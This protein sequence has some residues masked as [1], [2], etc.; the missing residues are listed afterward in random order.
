MGLVTKVDL[1]AALGISAMTLDAYIE[2]G[3]IVREPVK[4]RSAHLFAPLSPERLAEI[5]ELAHRH[6]AAACSRNSAKRRSLAQKALKRQAAPK[7]SPAPLPKPERAVKKVASPKPMPSVAAVISLPSERRTPK[8]R[9]FAA[10]KMS[11]GLSELH[12]ALA[13]CWNMNRRAAKDN[14]REVCA[15]TRRR[16]KRP[17]QTSVSLQGAM[18]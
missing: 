7:P 9:D 5:R 16:R 6:R 13:D 10:P 15:K 8:K 1:C 18:A 17:T 4:R 11:Q 12:A 2:R 3:W 14:W